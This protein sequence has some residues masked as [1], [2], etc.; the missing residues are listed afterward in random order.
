MT[1]IGRGHEAASEM[2]ERLAITRQLDTHRKLV[3]QTEQREIGTRLTLDAII[4]PASRPAENLDQAIT[5]ARALQCALLILCSHEAEPTA[6]H[7][8]LAGRSFS[9][10]IVVN[11][12]GHYHHELLNFRALAKIKDDLPEAC[13][14]YVTDL[15]TKR[16]VG[17]VLARMLGW[18]RI[19][20]LDD[21]IR[22]INPD[23]VHSTVSMLGSFPTAGMRVSRFPDNSAV[24]HAHRITG[25]LQDVFITGA[26]LAV[27]GQQ[28]TGFFP[29]IYNEDWLFFYDPVAGGK[30]G[31]SGHEVTQLRYD[32]F[33]DP[34]RAAWQEFGDILAE[35]LY[36]LLHHGMDW[37][38]ATDGYWLSFLDARRRFLKAILRR[39]DRVKSGEREQLLASVDMALKWSETMRPGLLERYTLLWRRD[40]REWRQRIAGVGQMPSLEAALEAL[41]LERST[42]GRIAH[43]V[44]AT[45]AAAAEE[46]ATMPYELQELND[47]LEADA[48]DDGRA[49]WG[50]GMRGGHNR[51]ATA[52]PHHGSP[53]LHEGGRFA[54]AWRA[55]RPGRGRGPAESSPALDVQTPTE[56]GYNL[57]SRG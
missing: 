31:S 30:L 14:W 12:P 16:N 6:V 55:F 45:T 1:I 15:S 9:D 22:D 5:L 3:S 34:D 2:S 46:P 39:A 28:N 21:D 11:L 18:R 48:E 54:S 8:L 44:P 51:R 35:G 52:L 10:A 40:L 26:A 47:L 33:A 56:T 43:L 27:D 32:P 36:A 4:V 23:G 13:S 57:G 41:G 29:D 7:K 24:C 53:G 19:F 42:D 37:R 38:Y 17:L 25:G 20:F 50:R 49:V